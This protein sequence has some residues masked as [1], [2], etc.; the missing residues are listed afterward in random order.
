M[1]QFCRPYRRMVRDDV[2]VL[3]LSRPM[4]WMSPCEVL[5]KSNSSMVSEVIV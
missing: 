2:I 3:L 5:E 4:P 1:P